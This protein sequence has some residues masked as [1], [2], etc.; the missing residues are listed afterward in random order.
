[1]NVLEKTSLDLLFVMDITGSMSSYL[2]QAKQNI[3]NIMNKIILECPGIDI[4]LGFI[5]YRDVYEVTIKNYVDI[6]FTQ[7]HQNLQDSIKNIIADG[8]ADTPE[9][10][11]WALER[12][13][14]KNWKNNA[15]FIIFVADSPCHGNKYH[16]S[17]IIDSYPN[18]APNRRNIEE[19]IA[20]LA[21]NNISL[22]CMKI[23]ESTNIMYKIFEN[24]YLNYDKCEFR[25]VSMN[26]Q[27]S[28][29]NIVIDSAAEIYINQRNIE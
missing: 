10:V 20:E 15:R 11:A 22:F 24:I 12:A 26:S 7:N 3:I 25:I 4:N 16:A 28:L 23:T 21:Q 29:S 2:N 6:D 18:G 13:L 9:D 8:G 17:N 5:G 1:M 19:L 27:Q 14:D